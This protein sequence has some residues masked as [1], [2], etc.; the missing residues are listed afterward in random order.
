MEQTI[1]DNYSKLILRF[2]KVFKCGIIQEKI[3][4]KI[5]TGR[6]NATFKDELLQHTAYQNNKY[7]CNVDL[8]DTQ[9]IIYYSYF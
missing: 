7:I 2:E 1:I 8:R 6:N 9:Q 3:S 4:L 5:T